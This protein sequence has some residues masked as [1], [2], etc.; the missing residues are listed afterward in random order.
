MTDSKKVVLLDGGVGQEIFKRTESDP[1]P[2]W[3]TQVMLD[4][5]G[6]VQS[7]HEEFIEA[8][9]RLITLNNYTATPQRLGRDASVDLLKPIHD[10]AIR[11]AHAAKKESGHSDVRIAGCLPP[12]IASYKPELSPCA[13]T[14]LESFRELVA[15]QKHGVEH[16]MVETAANIREGVAATLAAKE[17]GLSCWTAF[18]LDDDAIG[19][20][21]SGE[22]LEE[23]IKQVIEAGADAVMVN[24]SMPETIE[25]ALPILTG[26]PVPAGAY[27]NGF[28]TIKGFDAGGTVDALS[29]RKDLGPEIYAKWGLRCVKAGLQIIGGCCETGPDHIAALSDI[30][31]RNNYEISADL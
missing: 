7:V 25:A 19:L 26:L 6:L 30:L 28:T 1:S 24:C 2:L 16:F 17:T 22:K 8:G 18:T 11:I 23:A 14:C 27:A 29:A 12:L 9:A 21:R 15:L 10:A 13:E 4:D 31:L 20:L 3:S 5:P